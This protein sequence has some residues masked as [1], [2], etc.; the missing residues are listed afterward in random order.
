MTAQVRFSKM[1]GLGNDFVV[2][3]A[4]TQP[5]KVD[6]NLARK[7]AHRVYG[8]GC[9]QVLIVEPPHNPDEDF[10]YKIFNNDGT[11]AEQCGNGAR[12]V[13]RFVYEAGLIGTSEIVFGVQHGK[14]LVKLEPDGQVTAMLGQPSFEPNQVPIKALKADGIGRF[15][16]TVAGKKRSVA[17]LSL[18]NPHCVITV[19]S[20]REAQVD[21]IGAEL[22]KNG[23][24]PKGVNVGFVE[25][26][27]RNHVKLRVFERGAGETYAC[28]SGACAAVIAG[29]LHQ[30]LGH[31]VKV[32][33]KGGDVYVGWKQGEDV[34]LTGSCKR[35]FDGTFGV[36][37]KYVKAF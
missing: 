15:Q 2:I 11:I 16:L 28:G 8:I 9:D 21:D 29:I 27:A 24:F 18:G 34:A 32:D 20:I 13:G 12:C 10:Y 17:A 31:Q 3:D 6:S 30:D 14:M 25:V 19:P 33:M 36:E 4:I 23:A 26:L 1:H 37:E 5:I 35:L 7:L 22:Q